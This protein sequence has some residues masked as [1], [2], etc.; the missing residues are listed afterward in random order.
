MGNMSDDEFK[1][2]TEKLKSME[3]RMQDQIDDLENLKP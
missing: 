1:Q 2:K 3:K